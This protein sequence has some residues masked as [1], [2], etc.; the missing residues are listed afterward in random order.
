MGWKDNVGQ[1]D[2]PAIMVTGDV[3][4]R[5]PRLLAQ[6]DGTPLL[7]RELSSR[8][9]SGGERTLNGRVVMFY[10]DVAHVAH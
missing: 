9:Y 6:R 5:A 10:E 2:L 7:A 1:G 3:P 8:H 4:M